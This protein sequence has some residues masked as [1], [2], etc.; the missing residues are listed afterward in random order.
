MCHFFTLIG[1]DFIV[2]PLF[3]ESESSNTFIEKEREKKNGS[4]EEGWIEDRKEGKEEKKGGRKKRKE[5][6]EVR[7]GRKKGKKRKEWKE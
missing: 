5:G 6:N 7:N 4:R 1:S 3:S 2:V